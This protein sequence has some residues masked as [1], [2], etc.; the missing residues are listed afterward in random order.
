MAGTGSKELRT[1]YPYTK[2][3]TARTTK[4]TGRSM[5]QIPKK[6]LMENKDDAFTGV[7]NG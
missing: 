6:Y 3:L 1:K 4:Q 2:G 5:R 7:N